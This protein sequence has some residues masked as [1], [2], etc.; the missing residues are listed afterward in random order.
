MWTK[1]TEQIILNHELLKGGVY[2]LANAIFESSVVIKNGTQKKKTYIYLMCN[3]SIDIH[4]S[5]ITLINKII[6]FKYISERN[7]LIIATKII[8][9]LNLTLLINMLFTNFI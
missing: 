8:I 7:L 3:L 5:P 9:N 1:Y 2:R 4:P 6:F